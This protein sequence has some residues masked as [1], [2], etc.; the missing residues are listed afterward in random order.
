MNEQQ[1]KEWAENIIRDFIET[2][3][4]NSL[5]NAT[6]EKAWEDCLIGFSNG[7]DDI[8][9]A[10]KEHV[11]PFHMTPLEL[12]KKSFPDANQKPE[13]LSVISW[14]LPQTD[15]TKQDNRRET[16]YPAERWARARIFGE[17]ANVALRK[18][19]VASLQGKGYRAIA[20][21]LSPH[22][23]KKTSDKFGFASTWS[24]RHAAYASGLGT[25]GLCDGLITPK[26]KAMRCGSV[27]ADIEIPPTGRP[28]QDH[29]EYCLFFT[30]G[31]CKKCIPRCP[32]DAISE[33]GHDKV[34]CRTYMHPMIDEYVKANYHFDGY[35]CGLCQTGVPCESKIP[36]TNDVKE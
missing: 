26:G 11:G 20:P 28:Y 16:A 21:Q 22:W 24:E 10:Y 6:N 33:S 30:E 27:I 13:Q 32:A 4:E 7:A 5:E 36:T 14:I 17:K 19:V 1:L 15:R 29:H 23:E 2:S 34:K 25:F 35:G 3:T 31:K 18:Q 12:F 8:F 9:E